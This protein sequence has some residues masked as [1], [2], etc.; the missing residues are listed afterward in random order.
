VC[1]CVCV[2]VCVA[3][4]FDSSAVAPTDSRADYL[5]TSGGDSPADLASGPSAVPANDDLSIT[6]AHVAQ[7]V[8]ALPTP[9][10]AGAEMDEVGPVARTSSPM[11]PVAPA[12]DL[13]VDETSLQQAQQSLAEPPASIDSVQVPAL[14]SAASIV[15][16][17]SAPSVTPVASGL[18]ASDSG[19][20]DDGNVQ[21]SGTTLHRHADSAVVDALLLDSDGA[22]EDVSSD[23][24]GDAAGTLTPRRR[25]S[26]AADGSELGAPATK[27][28]HKISDLDLYVAD[29]GTV[30]ENVPVSQHTAIQHAVVAT[31]K[32]NRQ[33]YPSNSDDLAVTSAVDLK[34]G[35]GSSGS[36]FNP[37]SVAAAADSEPASSITG[38]TSSPVH[39]PSASNRTRSFSGRTGLVPSARSAFSPFT[40][41]TLRGV[42]P[43]AALSPGADRADGSDSRDG[44]GQDT[45]SGT[46][47]AD[48]AGRIPARSLSAAQVSAAA[49][50]TPIVADQSTSSV[51]QSI[52]TASPADPRKQAQQSAAP[53]SM[54]AHR[55]SLSNVSPSSFHAMYA[56]DAKAMPPPAVGA[57]V[58]TQHQG[59]SHT[60]GVGGAGMVVHSDSDGDEDYQFTSTGAAAAAA[61]GGSQAT[62]TPPLPHRV[63]AATSSQAQ[64][65]VNG[66]I[67][68]STRSGHVK[69]APSYDETKHRQ[70]P[71]SSG[72]IAHSESAPAANLAG[73][74]GI[75]ILSDYFA[76]QSK[77]APVGNPINAMSQDGDDFDRRSSASHGSSNGGVGTPSRLF[78]PSG[79]V[80]QLLVSR[81]PA[82][83]PSKKALLER[84][85]GLCATCGAA[86]PTGVFNSPRYCYYTSEYHHAS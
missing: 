23:R 27:R 51:R 1:V 86:L 49:T 60:G 80:I 64:I 17:D 36:S 35:Q 5:S 63:P 68:V 78:Q 70:P 20:G 75:R 16:T 3:P 8:M 41:P 24:G 71:A 38:S 15:N 19:G 52:N 28:V 42:G 29:D 53:A 58:S 83:K 10:A 21:A 6:T 74:D 66:H 26:V 84:Q 9:T 4:K 45:G 44:S 2:C 22:S 81:P 25:S 82:K 85:R 33:L 46:M 57:G 77:Q 30:S 7:A 12:D 13:S 39:I 65:R 54:A 34:A 43:L 11:P 40:S 37:P 14:A 76:G 73:S 18:V 72:T 55:H 67:P 61:A 50:G 62:V 31:G 47:Y 69:Q 56:A 48:E 32:V 79:Q 59:S